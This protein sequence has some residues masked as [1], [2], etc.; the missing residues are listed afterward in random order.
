VHELGQESREPKEAQTMKRN[1]L[2][3]LL[4]GMSLALLLS[5]GVAL[6]ASLKATVDKPCVQCFPP[7]GPPTDEYTAW[8]TI[9][10]F[11]NGDPYCFSIWVDGSLITPTPP[12]C[13]SWPDPPPAKYPFFIPCAME[14]GDNIAVGVL[15][16]EVVLPSGIEDLYGKWTWRWYNPTTSDSAEVSFLLAKDCAAAMFVP[17]PGSIL[18]LGSGLGGLAG[19]AT[20]RWRARE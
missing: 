16:D 18:L 1:W 2:R 13:S 8:M 4:W 7:P 20:L 9:T 19:Y 6:A 5:G 14:D 12:P 17:E 10:G 15:G 3:G 11:Q